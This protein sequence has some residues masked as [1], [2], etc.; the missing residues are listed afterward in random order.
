MH[1][2]LNGTR[3]VEQLKDTALRLGTQGVR[4]VVEGTVSAVKL[5][6]RLQEL[7]PRQDRE[8]R[9]TREPARPLAAQKPRVDKASER[10]QVE[11]R[12]TAGRVLEEARAAQERLKEARPARRPLKVSAAEALEE[13]AGTPKRKATARKTPRT[14]GRKTTAPATAP[15]RATA[16]PEGFKAKRGQKLKH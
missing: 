12:A 4:Y 3:L 9:V 1:M 2:E 7:M 15:K 14:Q 8:P 6:D 13:T 11:A 10:L 5:M 16:S